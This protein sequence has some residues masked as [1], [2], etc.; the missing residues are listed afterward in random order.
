VLRSADWLHRELA[1]TSVHLAPYVRAEGGARDEGLEGRMAAIR[2]IATLGRAAREEGGIKVRQRLDR[3]VCVAPGMTEGELADLVPLLAAELNVKR[4][5]LASSGAQLVRLEAKAN[6]RS[7]GKRFGKATPLAAKAVSALPDASL[8]AL[9]RGES[10]TIALDGESHPV[11]PEDVELRRHPVGE[12]LVQSEGGVF[13]ALDPT[14]TPELRA[15]GI[16]REVVSR[17]QRL[18]KETGLAVSDRIELALGS[19]TAAVRAALAAREEWIASEVL[20]VTITVVEQLTGTYQARQMVELD[21][22]TAEI[23]L[24][25]VG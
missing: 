1:G 12:L 8:Q 23:A 19:G 13:A 25:K 4:V 20:A 16:A 5:E 9:E 6:F 11:L 3:L 10:V 15:E 17:V 24:T 2:S 18:R 14:I 7:L 21:D 22:A